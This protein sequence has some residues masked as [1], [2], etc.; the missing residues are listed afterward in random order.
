MFT[1]FSQDKVSNSDSVKFQSLTKKD[2]KAESLSLTNKINLTE[3][4]LGA[5]RAGLGYDEDLEMYENGYLEKCL[6]VESD[7]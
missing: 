1:G 5:L 4:T 7:E 3:K 6:I 2:V